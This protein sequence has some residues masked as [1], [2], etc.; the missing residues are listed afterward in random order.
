MPEPISLFRQMPFSIGPP[1]TKMD[2]RFALAAPISCAGVVLSQPHSK[3]TPS[4]GFARI[5]SSTSM[6][7]RLR[8]IMLDG[9]MNGSPS[10]IVGN[11]S[12]KPPAD[13]TPR[14]TASATCLR[15]ALQFVSSDHELQIPMTG[16][17]VKT[18]PGKPSERSQDRCRNPSLS[19]RPNHSCER[20][21]EL[22]AGIRGHYMHKRTAR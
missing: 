20:N 16:L 15:W 8:N 18:L 3:T 22:S 1:V 9:R 7:M 12:G 5:D 13:H 4:M 17:P 19:P 2:G 10:E 21:F 11:S 14:F 6:A